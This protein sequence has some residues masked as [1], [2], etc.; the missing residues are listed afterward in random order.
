MDGRRNR[1]CKETSKQKIGGKNDKKRNEEET[2]RDGYQG[3][4]G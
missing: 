4:D 3:K 1:I 2:R